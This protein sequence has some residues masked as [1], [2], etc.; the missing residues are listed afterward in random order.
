MPGAEFV[1][2]ANSGHLPHEETVAEF[3]A[4][5]LPFVNR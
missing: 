1:E 4:A 5:V 2:I 3:M